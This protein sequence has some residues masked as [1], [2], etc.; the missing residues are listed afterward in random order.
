MRHGRMDHR[1]FAP[2]FIDNSTDIEVDWKCFEGVKRSYRG[3]RRYQMH[4]VF[5]GNLTVSL[6]LNDS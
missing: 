1:G 3:V 2:V 5:V 4:T 6:R